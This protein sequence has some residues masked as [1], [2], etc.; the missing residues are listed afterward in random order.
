MESE[1]E[2][3]ARQKLP[4]M[5]FKKAPMLVQVGQCYTPPV[6]DL[7]HDEYDTFQCAVVNPCN[8]MEQQHQF[9]VK[10]FGKEREYLVWIN[11]TE[12][13][14]SCSCRK[15]EMVGILCSHALKVLD[16]MNIKQIPEG[17]IIKRWRRDARNIHTPDYSV[18]NV[19]DP[20]LVAASRY[21]Q[22]CP[23]MV[24]L[25]ARCSELGPAHQLV[26]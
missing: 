25:A 11:A 22:L 17:Y 12:Q 20:K 8:T 18:S 4:R 10:L 2:Y 7:F 16:T 14:V 9:V 13:L 3:H 21:K 15:F 6:F 19:E 26:T 5:K 1:E 24:Q 23:R